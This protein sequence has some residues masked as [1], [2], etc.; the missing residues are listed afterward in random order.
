MLQHHLCTHSPLPVLIPK[1]EYIGARRVSG[2]VNRPR[3]QV[4]HTQHS[5]VEGADLRFRGICKSGRNV[6]QSVGRIGVGKGG[7]GFAFLLREQRGGN[8]IAGSGNFKDHQPTS[9]VQYLVAV[10]Q[11][12]PLCQPPSAP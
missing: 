3:G 6:Q 8:R 2:Q 7:C 11:K 4:K 12:R 1:R 10:E 9:A 5:T